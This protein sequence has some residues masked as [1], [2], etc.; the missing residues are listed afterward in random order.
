M[1][2]TIEYSG[3]ASDWWRKIFDGL[4]ASTSDVPVPILLG[5][6]PEV[7]L[8][9][10]SADVLSAKVA[11]F[12][13]FLIAA[14][15]LCGSSPESIKSVSHNGDEASFALFLVSKKL[16]VLMV[17]EFNG[18]HYKGSDVRN[19]SKVLKSASISVAQH[20]KR[21][22]LEHD[23][24]LAWDASWVVR[25]IILS[26]LV[27]VAIKSEDCLISA[28]SMKVVEAFNSENFVTR[29]DLMREHVQQFGFETLSMFDESLYAEGEADV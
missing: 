4:D 9:G 27:K 7:A 13:E 17:D 8:Y 1:S 23:I 12:T 2:A 19:L 18:L 28:E 16:I 21:K 26:E 25:A 3:A 15:E 20:F 5:L 10:S 24:R 22:V 29:I 14:D 6:Y 11:E